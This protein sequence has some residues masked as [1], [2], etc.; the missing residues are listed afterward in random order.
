MKMLKILCLFFLGVTVFS[1]RIFSRILSTH[2]LLGQLI[3]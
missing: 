2:M 1:S 3:F